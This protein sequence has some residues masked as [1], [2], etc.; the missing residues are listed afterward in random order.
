MN[1][2]IGDVFTDYTL[3]IPVEVLAESEVEWCEGCLHYSFGEG[4]SADRE[5]TEDCIEGEFIYKEYK[6]PLLKKP[7]TKKLKL[8]LDYPHLTRRINLILGRSYEQADAML[9]SWVRDQCVNYKQ[10]KI[11]TKINRERL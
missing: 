4:C 2:V 9:Y 1:K 8:H 6:K 7:K 5:Q 11:L 3:N 10:Y